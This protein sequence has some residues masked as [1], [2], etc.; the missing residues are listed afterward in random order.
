VAVILPNSQPTAIAIA[1]AV[2]GCSS[3]VLRTTSVKPDAAWTIKV[4]SRACHLLS[5]SLDLR[6]GIPGDTAEIFLYFS[7]P[8]TGVG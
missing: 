2:Y 4:V 3:M 7:V 1:T 6:P 8:L 5:L